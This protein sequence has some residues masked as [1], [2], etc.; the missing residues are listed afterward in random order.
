MSNNYKGGK[1]KGK[2]IKLQPGDLLTKDAFIDVTDQPIH[3]FG[4][5]P[6]DHEVRVFRVYNG[7]NECLNDLPEVPVMCQDGTSQLSLFNILDPTSANGR[8]IQ[9]DIWLF[10]QGRYR[11]EYVHPTVGATEIPDDVYV[12][13]MPDT[14]V[15][16][17]GINLPL[18]GE[19]SCPPEN[20]CVGGPDRDIEIG[21]V[22]Q[23]CDN[24]VPIK[25]RYINPDTTN[26]TTSD[27]DS[28][29]ITVTPDPVND[30]SFNYDLSVPCPVEDGNIDFTVQADLSLLSN[31]PVWVCDQNSPNGR[32][33][34]FIS[35]PQ[36]PNTEVTSNDNSVTVVETTLPNGAPNFD[37]SVPCPVENGNLDFTQGANPL[38]YTS[39]ESVWVCDDTQPSGR[40]RKFLSFEIPAQTPVCD[41]VV[42]QNTPATHTLDCV[43]GQLV[44][45]AL[46]P[47]PTNAIVEG[48]GIDVEVDT[49]DPN[50]TIF[51]IVLDLCELTELTQ[52]QVD[53]ATSVRY[54]A[55]VDGNNRLVPLPSICDLLNTIADTN[56]QVDPTTV[57]FVYIDPN[58]GDCTRGPIQA[59]DI[60]EQLNEVTDTNVS[61]DST[62]MD[63]IY[64]NPVTG[65]CNRGPIE[66]PPSCE[67][68]EFNAQAMQGGTCFDMVGAPASG[69]V[70]F[71]VNASNTAPYINNIIGTSTILGPPG[72]G[73][74]AMTYNNTNTYDVWV[75]MKYNFG[76]IVLESQ[77]RNNINILQSLTAIS[78]SG[79][80]PPDPSWAGAGAGYFDQNIAV[81]MAVA[82][83]SP[84]RNIDLAGTNNNWGYALGAEETR[85]VHFVPAGGSVTVDI[86]LY[87]SMDR[88][89]VDEY[90]HI[91][92]EGSW[93]A[94][95]AK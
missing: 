83:P 53:A 59:P 36:T 15:S 2:D 27:D 90:L 1:F 6:E 58:T 28:V 93:M 50:N 56:V 3:I 61:V 52:A 69:R 85:T 48:E 31:E 57:D 79:T 66:S 88:M 64:V 29:V 13:C 46:P 23:I 9:D 55:C 12:W 47:L 30:G 14:L 4:V 76:M 89:I 71:H 40:S 49:S 21:D 87:Y 72:F 42:E 74:T 20:F 67:C 25:V 73:T 77:G 7:E 11:I 26:T 63:F 92:V 80:L 10:Y 33:R 78:G 68:T 39:A 18:C 91:A 41:E 86:D 65:E 5:L 37:L 70:F 81:D 35:I 19:N 34:R 24:G 60:C 17:M 62:T 44:R 94:W 84:A 51:T 45:R 22:V 75:E 95:G 82:I 8:N 54:A 38:E 32:A 16:S 43:L